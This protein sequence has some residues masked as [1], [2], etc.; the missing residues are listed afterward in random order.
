MNAPLI[1]YEQIDA[2][3][4]STL[5]LLATSPLLLQHRTS[6]GGERP[7]TYE[8][9]LGRWIHC[10]LLEPERWAANHVAKPDFGDGRTKAAKEAKA[11]WLETMRPDVE[12]LDASDYTL[13]ERCAAAVLAHPVAARLL[14]AG[15]REEIVTW[16][17]EETGVACK[18]RLDFIAPGYILDLKSTRQQTLRGIT[19]DFAALLYH[20]QLAYYHDGAVA[21]RLIPRDAE[22][23]Y[24]IAVQTVEPFD[25]VPGRLPLLDLERG[26]SLYR[27]LLRR[28]VECQAAGWWPGIAPDLIDFSLPAWAPAGEPEGDGDW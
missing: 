4:W 6:H 7:D 25:V 13:V 1:P 9:R 24:A 15:R 20:G 26:R 14:Y 8:L 21:A 10:A 11:A 5:K 19:R 2:L 16:T 3:N 22:G 18:G 12:V 23:P 17:D 27:S 28:Y